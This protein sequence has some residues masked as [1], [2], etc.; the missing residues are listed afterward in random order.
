MYT[1]M[2]IIRPCTHACLLLHH[3]HMYTT[4]IYYTLQV[5]TVARWTI[6]DSTTG[7]KAQIGCFEVPVQTID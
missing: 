4:C 7:N 1:C 3:V 5:T 6:D 2:Y